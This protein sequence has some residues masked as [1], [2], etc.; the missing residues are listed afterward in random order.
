MGSCPACGHR[1][2]GEERLTAWLLSSQHLDE[3]ELAAAAARIAGGE[4]LQPTPDQIARA[5]EA[6]KP[7]PEERVERPDPDAGLGFRQK[8]LFVG[9]NVVFT[10]LFGLAAWWSWRTRRP[11]AAR[12][13]L[14]LTLPV[15]A[16]F[17]VA[18][19]TMMWAQATGRL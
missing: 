2:Q 11:L 10:P 16:F 13:A 7:V 1:P 4:P 5:R 15:V 19:L 8:L 6:L 12:D 18:W 17:G 9:V 3:D 14:Q